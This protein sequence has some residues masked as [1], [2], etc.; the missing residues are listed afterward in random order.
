MF[1]N[2]IAKIALDSLIN[3]LDRTLTATDAIATAIDS[4]KEDMGDRELLDLRP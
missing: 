4:N 2:P 3:Q 1:G